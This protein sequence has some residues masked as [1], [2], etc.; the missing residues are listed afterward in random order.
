M[1]ST[2]HLEESISGRAEAADA[3][4][5]AD[6]R[7][8]GHQLGDTLVRQH[9]QA[10][11]ATVEEVRHLA[12]RLRQ[13][14]GP[15]GVTAELT[16][17]L[18]GLDGDRAIHLVRAFTVYFHLANIAEQEHRIE[19]LNVGGT[20]AGNHFGQTVRSLLD[21]GVT[22]AEIGDLVDRADFRPVFT[23]H[24]TEASRR[25][26][27]NK[28]ATIADLLK[29]R[30]DTRCTQIERDRID[31]RIDEMIEAIW[32]TDEIRHE[33]P[34]PFDEAKFVLYYLSQT[35]SEALPDLFDTIAAT[36]GSIGQKM[37]PDHVPIRFGSWVGGDR[38]GNPNVSP[39]TTVAVLD[40][41]R[42]RAI[43]LLINEIKQLSD[44]A[45]MSGRLY[46]ISEEMEQIVAQDTAEH[47]DVL[48]PARLLEPYRL[49]CAVIEKRLLATRDRGTG[50]YAS[51]D[52]L[53][54]ELAAMDRSLRSHGGALIADGRLARVRRI[55]SAIGFHFASLD[56]REHSTRH[57]E[58]LA[59]LFEPLGVAYKDMTPQQRLA[60]LVEELDSR[61]PLA[62]PHG[63]DEHDNLTLFRTL[64]SIMDR[65]GDQVI[66]AY[67]VSMT[68]GVDDILAP[69]LLARE[70]GLVDL[71]QDIARL[72]FVPLFETIEDLEAIG[73]TLRTL[74]HNASYRHLLSLRGDEQEVM[75]GYS[76]S[77]K[78]GG[79]TTSQWKIHKALRVIQQ[80]AE[81]AGIRIRVFH[82]RGGTIGRGGGPTHASILSQ[83]PGVVDGEIKLTEQ[84]EV[85][86]DKY[87][88]PA[89]AR[90]NLNLAV[91]ALLESSLAHKAP[92]HDKDSISTWY[93]IME[94]V[95]DAAFSAYR[96]FVETPGLPEYFTTSTPVE[97]LGSMN[98]G[99]RRARRSAADVGIA[100]LRA[101]PWVFGWTQ[102]RQIIPGWFG[103]GTGLHAAMEAGHADDLRHMYA[104]WHFFSTFVSNVEMTLAKTDLA[105][106]RHYVERLVDQKLHHLFDQVVEEHRLTMEM[107]TSITG[108]A[109][110][111]DKPMLR[112]TLE[113]RDAY[114]DPIS[115][116]QVELLT[117]SRREKSRDRDDQMQ[118]ALL[119]SINGI[120]AGLRNTG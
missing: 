8:L 58:A 87:G 111:S 61:R 23:A 80:V 56:I 92:R 11:L 46:Q 97:E 28:L 45:S 22:A 107:I 105:I 76:D 51:P 54:S 110:L 66:D 112:R 86:A 72:D 117:R 91:S 5:R 4:L 57:H 15:T 104:E 103:A 68:R 79:I 13:T 119:L 43:T 29:A 89:I 3:A 116:L 62:P 114:L 16:D 35:V 37:R 108:T 70:V 41:Q 49:H 90:R 30:G 77:N 88:L 69:V 67:I 2:P 120:A 65:D 33:R 12:Q 17:L 115:V 78:D 85:I 93:E 98:I 113:V 10:L 75:V 40:L 50:T 94:Q 38:D 83:P 55:V 101:I 1:T 102:S 82:G 39:D 100:D 95:S 59:A 20:R 9:G 25:S 6:I 24:P 99:S 81:E 73:S 96:Q 48:T 63:H 18:A 26:I 44:D 31:R 14:G 64:R 19:D 53:T 34:D 32:Q 84:G 60:R 106:A 47:S 36:L 74:F 109:L 27:L 118:R 52:Q 21:S 7:R 71:G 42:D